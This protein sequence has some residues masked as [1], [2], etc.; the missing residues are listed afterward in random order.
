MKLR[1]KTK[2]QKVN[3]R[4]IQRERERESR[5]IVDL[6]FAPLPSCL[7]TQISSQI[8]K[9][10]KQNRIEQ[11]MKLKLTDNC[12][13]PEDGGRSDFSPHLIRF[14]YVS[15]SQK[16]SILA[17]GLGFRKVLLLLLLLLLF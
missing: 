10:E 12:V 1:S 4:K 5:N 16:L 2:K 6:K 15:R 17:S 3:N 14:L 7:I 8:K 13:E 11:N 9:N